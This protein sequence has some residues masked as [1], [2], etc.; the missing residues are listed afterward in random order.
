MARSSNPRHGT[1]ARYL[2]GCRC[3]ACGTGHKEYLRG[4]SRAIAYG[5]H[6]PFTSPEPARQHLANLAAAG[7]TWQQAAARSGV[8]KGTIGR[9]RAGTGTKIRVATETAILAVPVP[10]RQPTIT[11]THR[12]IQALMRNGWSLPRLATRL[13]VGFHS[14][15]RYLARG[16][17]PATAR[18]IAALYEQLQHVQPP[19]ATREDRIS[20]TRTR[21]RA[22]AAGWAPPAAWDETTIDDPAAEPCWDWVRPVQGER[23]AGAALAAEIRHLLQADSEELTAQRL[24]ITHKHLKDLLRQHPEPAGEENA[25]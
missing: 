22:R 12:R 24:G 14:A 9:I 18:K 10:L 4:R 11:G 17:Q 8:T 16:V 5:R 7:V 1:R 21:D 15:R 13:G 19:Q 2:R 6:H 25:A 20:V 23:L 3:T